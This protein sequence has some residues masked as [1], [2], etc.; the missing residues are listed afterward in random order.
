MFLTKVSQLQI[1]LRNFFPVFLSGV[2]HLWQT[3]IR[4]LLAV[5]RAENILP[6]IIVTDMT[7]MSDNSSGYI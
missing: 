2:A 5:C 1:S 6:V 7:Y 4:Q 3:V